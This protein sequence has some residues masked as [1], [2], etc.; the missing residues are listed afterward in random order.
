MP[1]PGIIFED[2]TTIFDGVPALEILHWMER[3]IFFRGTDGKSYR[4]NRESRRTEELIIT[5]RGKRWV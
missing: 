1:I 2:R 3:Y 4:F 5:P